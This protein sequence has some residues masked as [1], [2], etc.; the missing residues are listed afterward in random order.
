[1]QRVALTVSCVLLSLSTAAAAP[2]AFSGTTA[3]EAYAGSGRLV[4]S[5]DGLD[6]LRTLGEQGLRGELR[7]SGS[8]W[9]G[10]LRA[11]PGAR[12]ALEGEQAQVLRVS[13]VPVDGGYRMAWTDAQG[14][15][16]EELWRPM[17]PAPQGLS[18][19][20]QD[21]FAQAIAAADA[22]NVPAELIPSGGNGVAKLLLETG[23]EI[24][25]GVRRLIAGAEHEVML[26]SFLWGTPCQAGDA[27]FA[28]LKELEARRRSEGA[29]APV[30]VFVV[31]NE[32]WTV[33]KNMTNLARDVAGAGLDPRYV[34]LHTAGFAQRGL[35]GI[36][37]TKACLVDGARA[38]LT[39][40]NVHPPQDAPDP[41]FELGY[42][43]EGPV[44][45]AMRAE[46]A[47]LWQR[48]T[49]EPL[50]GAPPPLPAAVEGGVPVALASKR[51]QGNPFAKR[52]A[53][54]PRESLVGAFRGATRRIRILS[55][56]LNDRV[57][58]AELVAAAKRGV[59]V[60]L[61]LSKNKGN[62]RLRIPGQGG[63]VLRATRRLREALEDDPAALARLDMR[64]W[65]RDG[66]VAL[67]GDVGGANHAKYCT[68]DGE[69]AIVGS[70]NHDVQSMKYSRELA[71]LV[72]DPAT[73][74]AWDRQVF[75][76]G[77]ARGVPVD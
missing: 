76:P 43:L 37:H 67:E 66:L 72:A 70:T 5:A 11:D 36:V 49:G 22:G 26:Q 42:P 71:L 27:I 46:Y 65:S 21:V 68:V 69:L 57:L 8:G 38:I 55:P 20:A 35:F 31:V 3:G 19:L 56:Q 32:H 54:P 51:A 10:V 34:E 50:P 17:L 14:A 74:Q 64:W 73:V 40:A 6:V 12:G 39:S 2:W 23:P 4:V 16:G 62:L 33:R 75:E 41:W 18:P 58:R 13:V 52:F 44:C 77:F 60:Q 53:H 61:L 29:A 25:A 24:F 7:G 59:E 47:Q 63:T 15:R 48:A 9:E 28:G 45:A 30:R 1:M